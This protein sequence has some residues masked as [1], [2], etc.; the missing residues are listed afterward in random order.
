MLDGKRI[1]YQIGF[2]LLCLFSLNSY[3]SAEASTKYTAEQIEKFLL[4]AKDYA[5]TQGKDKAVSA[6][7]DVNNKQF[8]QGSLYVFA[9]DFNGIALAHMKPAIVGTNMLEVKDPDGV[10][11]VKNMMDI[12]KTKPNGGWTEYMW[13]N[14]STNKVEKKYT[15]VIK[16]DDTWWIAAGIYASEKM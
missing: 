5:I 10:F 14:P 12:A 13:H 2:L 9:V 6:F 15:F 7:R 4:Q 3:V 8:V 16:V 11:L 1:I